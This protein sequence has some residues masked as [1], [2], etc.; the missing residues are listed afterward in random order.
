[1]PAHKINLLQKEDFEKKP[2]GRFLTWAL[3]VG[4][5]IVVF[6]ELIVILAFLSRFK[7]DQDLATLHEKIKEKQFI[8]SSSA[9]FENTFRSTQR[10]IEEV[11]GIEDRQV[12]ID[13]LMA[14]ISN[15]TPTD[16]VLNNLTYKERGFSLTGTALNEGSLNLYLNSL[17]KSTL[18]TETN[19]YNVMKGGE[20]PGL[21]FTIKSRLK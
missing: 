6:T 14:E 1:M 8:I 3:D 4:R 16:I 7:L 15:A 19:L 11:K 21:T 17:S 12:D 18:F 20:K 5:W 10:R 13:K 9:N 2:I